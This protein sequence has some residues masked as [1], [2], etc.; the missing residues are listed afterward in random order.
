MAAPNGAPTPLGVELQPMLA[1]PRSSADAAAATGWAVVDPPLAPPA[2]GGG[3]DTP[4]VRS[5]VK[6]LSLILLWYAFS[7]CLSLYNRTLL[8]HGH[9]VQGKGAFPAP[10]L[11]TALQFCVQIVLARLALA[12]GVERPPPGAPR[13]PPLSWHGWVTQVVPNGVCTGLDIGLSNFSL[14]LITL[15]FYTMC[16]STTP[17][18]LLLFAFIWGLEK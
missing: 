10:L 7:T 2:R 5:A 8:G 3:W 1:G 15:S 12:A 11:M 16:K 6:N 14:S 13:P 9:G 18:F 4:L 17:L